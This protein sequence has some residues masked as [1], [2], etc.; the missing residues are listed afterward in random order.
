MEYIHDMMKRLAPKHE[1]HI[2][3]Y[4]HNEKRLTGHHETSSK[5][6]F[7][8]GVGNR[9]SSI[10]IPTSTAADKKGYIEDRRPASDIDPYV[11]GAVMIDTTLLKDSLIEPLYEHYTTWKKW[12]KTAQIEEC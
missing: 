4:G 8:Y 10:R 7:S 3:L 1:F 11:V 5:E 6:H 12:L 2:E 9:A